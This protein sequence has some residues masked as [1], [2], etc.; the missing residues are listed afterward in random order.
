MQMLNNAAVHGALMMRTSIH[1]YPRV[2][3]FD[4]AKD[5]TH[6]LKPFNLLSAKIGAPFLP[7]TTPPSFRY[8]CPESRILAAAAGSHT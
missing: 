6:L 5:G 2:G 3:D 1:A 8:H 4:A 7:T